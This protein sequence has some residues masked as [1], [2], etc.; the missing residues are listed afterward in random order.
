[1]ANKRGE[2]VVKIKVDQEQILYVNI[3]KMLSK[4]KINSKEDKNLELNY[5][6]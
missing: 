1:M 3:E 2:K 5:L 4:K 6:T